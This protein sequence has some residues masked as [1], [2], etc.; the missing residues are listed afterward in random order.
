[1]Q[2][3]GDDAKVYTVSYDPSLLQATPT[4]RRD[5]SGGRR[6]STLPKK[7]SF[8]PGSTAPGQIPPP[9]PM[10]EEKKMKI[11]AM[12]K[13]G[14]DAPMPVIPEGKEQASPVL[15]NRTLRKR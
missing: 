5:S 2:V 12:S 6:A 11:E 13:L 7:P 3:T 15:V 10:D 14:D 8:F 9:N 4:S 1:M